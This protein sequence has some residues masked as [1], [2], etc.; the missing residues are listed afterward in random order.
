M[1]SARRCAYDLQHA[2]HEMDPDSFFYKEFELR[3]QK[4]IEL[5]QTGNSAKDYYVG[6]YTLLQNA[7]DRVEKLKAE[8]K[9]HGIPDPTIDDDC[10]F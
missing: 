1:K 8:L 4:W 2:V 3:S 10:P 6:I 5:F 9:K 7:E